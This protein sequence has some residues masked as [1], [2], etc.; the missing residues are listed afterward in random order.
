MILGVRD[1]VVLVC[2]RQPHA[3]L[4][5]ARVAHAAV[6]RCCDLYTT[7]RGGLESVS[8][9]QVYKYKEQRAIHAAVVCSI[10]SSCDLGLSVF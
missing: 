1:H 2:V 3:M 4:F 9:K 10:I 6:K 5:R 7:W 8:L